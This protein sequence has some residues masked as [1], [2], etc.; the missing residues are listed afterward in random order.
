MIDNNDKVNNKF[1]FE[2]LNVLKLVIIK[3][4]KKFLVKGLVVELYNEFNKREV[5]YLLI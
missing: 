1:L 4:I 2:M 5:N 3:L